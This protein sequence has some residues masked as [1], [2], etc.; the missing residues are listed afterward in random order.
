MPSTRSTSRL[1]SHFTWL[2]LLLPGLALAHDLG[3]SSAELRF[4][5]GRVQLELVLDAPDAETLTHVERRSALIERL[6]GAVTVEIDGSGLPLASRVVALGEGGSAVDVVEFRAPTPAT[7]GELKVRFEP[8]LGDVA[9]EVRAPSGQSLF[10]QLLADGAGTPAIGLAPPTP[11]A[12]TFDDGVSAQGAPAVSA[13]PPSQR[14]KPNDSA[15]SGVGEDQAS[16]GAPIWLAL[17]GV[18]A[19][20]LGGWAFLRRPSRG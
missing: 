15:A 14:T 17:L 7:L 9:L 12:R 18:G 20:A 2:L 6:Q 13:A 3:F 11:R 8:G 16:V 4:V 5:E 1:A 10:R 19:L